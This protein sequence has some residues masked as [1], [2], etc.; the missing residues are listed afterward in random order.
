[1]HLYIALI[2]VTVVPDQSFAS[3]KKGC[4]NPCNPEQQY[5]AGI[6]CLNHSRCM[7]DADCINT[8]NKM[9]HPMCVGPTKCEFSSFA[10]D[11]S[12]SC[13]KSC[14]TVCETDKDCGEQQYCA[15]GVC[16]DYETCREDK[17]CL[18]PSNIWFAPACAGPTTCK[19]GSCGKTCDTFCKSNEE[20][21]EQQY[22]NGNVCLDHTTCRGENDCLNKSNIWPQDKCIGPITC[23]DNSCTKNCDDEMCANNCK[24]W[25]N[26]CN[27][28][29]CSVDNTNEVEWCT[30]KQCSN[31]EEAYC[32]EYIKDAEDDC[33]SDKDCGLNQ[34]CSANVCR[35][36][37]TCSKDVDCLNPSNFWGEEKC[38]GFNKCLD[39]SCQ[40]TCG[41]HCEDKSEPMQC[42][43]APCKET[44][45][46]GM[47]CLND[48]CGGCNAIVFD[49]AGN[50]ICA[51]ETDQTLLSQPN[52]GEDRSN[53]PE[54]DKTLLSQPNEGEDRSKSEDWS[55]SEADRTFYNC[56]NKFL[57]ATL[58]L[59]FY[60]FTQFTTAY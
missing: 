40:R 47:V 44:V 57:V 36:Y 10:K 43:V 37:S 28:C 33:K 46:D 23:E 17:D 60:H 32:R 42:L 50:E 5:C 29:K 39:G 1:M 20:C 19:D 26:G 4:T 18:E 58:C 52:E 30:E 24:F 14:D 38:I 48:Y 25:Y 27:T 7:E 9:I 41:Y 15:G 8:S 3:A 16:L 6:S 12:G 21:G 13:I 31:F 49:W 55:K 54:T 45:C 53:V 2:F 35:D 59:S 51:P 11:E 56:W 22:C 34:Y